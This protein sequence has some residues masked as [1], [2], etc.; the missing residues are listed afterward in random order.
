MDSP[1]HASRT[2]S[3]VPPPGRGAAPLLPQSRRST[4]GRRLARAPVPRQQ[5]DSDTSESPPPVACRH[6]RTAPPS[7]PGIPGDSFPTWELSGQGSTLRAE[8]SANAEAGP[9]LMSNPPLSARLT[10][11]SS[12]PEAGKSLEMSGQGR[13]DPTIHRYPSGQGSTTADNPAGL[14]GQG[15]IPPIPDHS[16]GLHL[17]DPLGM[18]PFAPHHRRPT[19]IISPMYHGGDRWI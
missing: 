18:I 7:S 9:L 13:E 2:R 4:R 11:N 1:H 12:Q 8:A 19:Q 5:S 15:S 3:R 10:E 6:A 17:R 14:S 16:Y